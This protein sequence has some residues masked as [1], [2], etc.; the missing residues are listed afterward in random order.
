MGGISF[1]Q[2]PLSGA[3]DPAGIA[4]LQAVQE[5]GYQ[6]EGSW[7]RQWHAE[8]VAG[9]SLGDGA[10]KLN[11]Q[12]EHGLRSASTRLQVVGWI[13]VL[14]RP[15]LNVVAPGQ[16]FGPIMDVGRDYLGTPGVPRDLTWEIQEPFADGQLIPI[17]IQAGHYVTQVKAPTISGSYRL[18]AT[19]VADPHASGIYEFR[20][21]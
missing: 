1:T 14:P 12:T 16:V 9:S 17:D 15:Q 21:Q 2:G 11:S 8:V 10:L 19:A 6:E 3:I 18:R 7:G 5:W 13:Q 4:S 20:V